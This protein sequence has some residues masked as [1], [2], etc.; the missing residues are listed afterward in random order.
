MIWGFFPHDLGNWKYVPII[1]INPPLYR[2]QVHGRLP[3]T[4]PLERLVPLE[5][6]LGVANSGEFMMFMGNLQGRCFSRFLFSDDEF[7]S[8]SLVQDPFSASSSGSPAVASLPGFQWPTS[9]LDVF[10]G[11]FGHFWHEKIAS[12]RGWRPSPATC[13]CAG[14]PTERG[15]DWV[16]LIHPG[17]PWVNY[18]NRIKSMWKTHRAW[19][20]DLYTHGGLHLHLGLQEGIYI[21]SWWTVCKKNHKGGFRC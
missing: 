12:G 9:S 11:C 15:G 10:G 18:T 1:S 13:R 3:C 8:A 17:Y 4:E 16:I 21:F 7:W 5:G 19:E 2:E 6:G 14:V 20:H